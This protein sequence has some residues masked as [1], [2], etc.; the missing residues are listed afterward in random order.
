MNYLRYSDKVI[1]FYCFN[2]KDKNGLPCKLYCYVVEDRYGNTSYYFTDDKEEY[3]EAFSNYIKK[4]KDLNNER[5][6]Q[7]TKYNIF[8]DYPDKVNINCK[9]AKEVF[10]RIKRANKDEELDEKEFMNAKDEY[11][12]KEQDDEKGIFARAKDKLKALGASI[13]EK[14][15]NVKKFALRTAI[16]AT[17]LVVGGGAIIFALN[18][19]NGPTAT[20]S[21]VARIDTDR[22]I[23]TPDVPKEEEKK[24]E[25]ENTATDTVAETTSYTPEATTT[26]Y[27]SNS[28]Y[29]APP[30]NT[31]TSDSSVTNSELPAFQD[32]TQSID[33]SND[34]NTNTDPSTPSEDDKYDNVIIE[35]TP[36]TGDNSGDEE[37]TIPDDD[38]T[39]EIDVPSISDDTDSNEN[40]DNENSNDSTDD[41]TP[42]T[43]PEEDIDIG[44]IEVEPGIPEGAIDPD[45]SYEYEE[46][47]VDAPDNIDEVI[48][49]EVEPLPD[50]SDTATGDY[51]T[52]EDE[53]GV[54]KDNHQSMEEDNTVPVTQ[55]TTDAVTQ[56]IEVVPVEQDT[57]STLPSP[58]ETALDGNYVNNEQVVE[59]VVEAMANGDDSVNIVYNTDGSLSVG[60]TDNT[61]MVD[62]SS[63][64]K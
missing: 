14:H 23:D 10:D 49:A 8:T 15:P 6:N 19:S 16:V 46:D 52:T 36:S 4:N 55:E 12:L 5:Y 22:D 62:T 50:P 44:D 2:D 30:T 64:T 43:P 1:G 29:T 41:N 38:Y 9:D 39:E 45:L 56:D 32:P 53:W 17:A 59:Q 57:T 26:Y 33:D 11:L 27:S 7:S 58:E 25:E 37:V 35:E 40:N 3:K 13:T 47:Y 34:Q 20:N 61:N 48:D 42:E 28:G 31:S 18:R 21:R 60:Y 63:M 54:I 24:E 51:V